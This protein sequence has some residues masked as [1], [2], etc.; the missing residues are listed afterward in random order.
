M[1]PDC[2]HEPRGAEAWDMTE[3]GFG[4]KRFGRK[5]TALNSG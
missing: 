4:V 5:R 1:N 3:L 2:P